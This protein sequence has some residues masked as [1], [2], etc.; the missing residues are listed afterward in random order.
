M[1]L[2]IPAPPAIPLLGNI[3]SIEKEVPLHSFN[4]LLK[5]YGEIV[6][7]NFIGQY[8]LVDISLRTLS[9]SSS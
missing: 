2:P 9:S 1:A 4:I 8:V 3:G 5:Q 7:L 6:R